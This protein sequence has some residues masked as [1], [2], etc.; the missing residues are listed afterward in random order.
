MAVFLIFMDSYSEGSC[1]KT[2]GLENVKSDV[3]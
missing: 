2:E 1:I 3:E